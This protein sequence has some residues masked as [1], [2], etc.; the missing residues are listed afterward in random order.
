MQINILFICF[1]HQDQ[2][3]PDPKGAKLLRLLK[4]GLTIFNRNYSLYGS[5]Y[6]MSAAAKFDMELQFVYL[7]HIFFSSNFSPLADSNILKEHKKIS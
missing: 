3:L 7:L 1:N 2:T 4:R 6:Q 5:I